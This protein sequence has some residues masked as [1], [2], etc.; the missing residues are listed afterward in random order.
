M[1]SLPIVQRELA[2]AARRPAT[3][4]LRFLL[5][6]AVMGTWV[7]LVLLGQSLFPGMPSGQVWFR[8]MSALALAFCLMAG[9]FL[10]A[11]CL[12][13]ERREGTLGLLLLTPLGGWSVVMGKLLATSLQAFCGLLA[14]LPAFGLPLLAGGV[15]PSE[16]WRMSLA[17]VATLLLSLSIGMAISAVC[18][19]ARKA[20]AGTLVAAA[21]LAA[22]PPCSWWLFYQRAGP[23]GWEF[24]FAPSPAW[25][26]WTALEANHVSPALWW[27]LV[28]TMLLSCCGLVFAGW[29]VAKFGEQGNR[30][31]G[32]R[33][34]RG[35]GWT[36]RYG[37]EAARNR[38][39]RRLEKNP[40]YWL[41][42]R[43]R[44]PQWTALGVLGAIFTVWLGLV[45]TG[46]ALEDWWGSGGDAYFTAGTFVGYGAHQ[47]FKFLFAWEA[48]RRLS[49][50]RRSGAVELL[51]LTPLSPESVVAGQRRAL[52]SAFLWASLVPITINIGIA[53]LIIRD[54]LKNAIDLPNLVQPLEMLTLGALMLYLDCRTLAYVGI[55]MALKTGRHARS[56]WTSLSGVMLA[57]W[58]ALGLLILL[59]ANGAEPDR[60]TLTTVFTLWFV[61]SAVLDLALAAWA[62]DKFIAEFRQFSAP[63]PF[64][65]GA[66]RLL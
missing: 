4:R 40:F 28:T 35:W 46:L 60:W 54:A 5:A 17:L 51:A 32:T 9:V 34:D 63:A 64:Q 8:A 6:L 59:M 29:R 61:V 1:L 26:Y 53:A 31:G 49:D 24:L 66:A 11:D 37:S 57:P 33:R 15:T 10:T 43:D 44:E 13:E 38:W 30:S 55:R 41:A 48:S 45:I 39:R 65:P 58:L 2:V 42:R 18:L 7:T 21:C 52:R 27:A 22:A 47:I 14:V 16:V 19:E 56:V 23:G 50:D 20:V 36:L 25:L 12:S 62:K 3:H